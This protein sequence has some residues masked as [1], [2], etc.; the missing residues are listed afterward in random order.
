MA[1]FE[2]KEAIATLRSYKGYDTR[3][4]RSFEQRFSGWR[5]Y[6]SDPFSFELDIEYTGSV[7]AVRGEE[8]PGTSHHYLQH[9][10]RKRKASSITWSGSGQESAGLAAAGEA[11]ARRVKPR[12][13]EKQG[14]TYLLA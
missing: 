13:G 14:V 3:A 11:A 12:E 6:R 2:G 9:L 7:A 8:A 1:T 10:A 4:S 5:S